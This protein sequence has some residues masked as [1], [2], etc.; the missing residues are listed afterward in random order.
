MAR[1]KVLTRKLREEAKKLKVRLHLLTAKLEQY[2]H[3]GGQKNT[4]DAFTT[5]KQSSSVSTAV[6]GKSGE[7]SPGKHIPL[8]DVLRLTLEFATTT[9]AT[10]SGGAVT[11]ES[12][13]TAAACTDASMSTS[14]GSA[15]NA[16][17][18][19]RGN[20][21]PEDVQMEN[22]EGDRGINDV[23]MMSPAQNTDDAAG[24]KD[25]ESNKNWQ[26]GLTWTDAL[27]NG[28][29]SI[30]DAPDRQTIDFWNHFSP[31]ESAANPAKKMRQINPLSPPAPNQISPD[32]LSVIQV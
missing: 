6:S 32:E 13:A 16:A 31:S 2:V 1:N 4:T 27:S 8:A 26:A 24:S 28:V 25:G 11:Q 3:F 5:M 10:S 19:P 14:D 23:A 12:D 22:V 21:S 9:P 20:S 15:D 17:S 18:P 30:Q 7:I 29:R